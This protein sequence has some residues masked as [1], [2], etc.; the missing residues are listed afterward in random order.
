MFENELITASTI[1]IA[2]VVGRE[3]TI[4]I[5][6]KYP[7]KLKDLALISITDPGSK[8]DMSETYSKFKVVHQVSFWDVEAPFNKYEP[9][10]KEQAEDLIS[11]IYDN[12]DRQFFI[13]CEAGISRSAGVALAI[14]AIFLYNGSLKAIHKAGINPII[15][16]YRYYPNH[17][18]TSEL[19]E[20]YHRLY[21]P[22]AK[23]YK[24]IHCSS[25][26]I[27]SFDNFVVGTKNGVRIKLCPNCFREVP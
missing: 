23:K 14:E 3:E 19:L 13:H 27:F 1:K 26:S 9:I 10:N 11:F 8:E 20:A 22:T 2:A 15:R 21:P 25:D 6:K 24:C 7:E 4:A 17:K 18:V 12:L 16:F 5:A